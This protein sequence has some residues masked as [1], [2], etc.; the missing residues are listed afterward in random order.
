MKYIS[1]AKLLNF[2]RKGGKKLIRILPEFYHFLKIHLTKN[3]TFIKRN[4][5]EPFKSPEMTKIS[6]TCCIFW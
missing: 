2:N 3:Y 1:Q 4:F 6:K 5:E